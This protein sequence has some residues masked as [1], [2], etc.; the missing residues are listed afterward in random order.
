MNDLLVQKDVFSED[1]NQDTQNIIL[2]YF[3][4]ALFLSDDDIYIKRKY[5]GQESR[6]LRGSLSLAQKLR[7]NLNWT[8]AL[9]WMP[10]L[11]NFALSYDYKFLDL[12]EILAREKNWPLFVRPASGMKEFSGNVYSR[13]KLMEEAA[14]LVSNKN[15]NTSL[16]CLYA[17]PRPLNREWR[18]VFVNGEVSS[19]CQYMVKGK[20]EVSSDFPEEVVKYA[21]EISQHEFFLNKFEYV[22]DIGESNEGLRLIEINAFETASFYAS[23]LHKIYSDWAGSYK[24]VCM[25]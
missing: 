5:E 13:E 22:I 12:N 23:D 1:E 6:L 19:G 21:I 11:K 4:K 3:P 8:N 7:K 16:I 24:N 18:V 10:E 9:N 15:V 14:F 17:S 2:K 20:K 25:Y